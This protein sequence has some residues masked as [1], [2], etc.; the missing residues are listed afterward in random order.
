ML[1]KLFIYEWK[2]TWKLVALLNLIVIGVTAIGVFLLSMDG[3]QNMDDRYAAV[4]GTIYGIVYIIA[5]FALSIAV[6]VYFY[7][8][9]FK[10]FYSDE[11]Y[12]MHTLPVTKHDLILSKAFV[13]S[14]WSLIS[15]VVIAVSVA[16]IINALAMM[17]GQNIWA[18]ISKEIAK[19]GVQKE[20][21]IIG[22]LVVISMIAGSFAGVMSG[23]VAVS[24]GQLFPKMKIL[25]SIGAFVL[26]SF[27]I[28]VA[29]S[30]GNT[31]MMFL[32]AG[33]SAESGM[34]FAIASLIYTIVGAVVLAVAFY[35]ATYYIM[36]N[37]LNLD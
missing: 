5:I 3:W 11:G 26:I 18:E 30:V 31:Q 8:R 2:E 24:I 37:K 27:A 13:A 17:D 9:F 21:T 22:I 7:I 10:N 4:L 23:Y 1:K 14:I 16:L 32:G 12:L 33:Y 15:S 19:A 28:Q 36:D 34:G 29:G 25:A 20:L 6:G 35:F